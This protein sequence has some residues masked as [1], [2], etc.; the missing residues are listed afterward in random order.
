MFFYLFLLYFASFVCVCARA[1]SEVGSLKFCFGQVN[2]GLNDKLDI[3]DVGWQLN[4]ELPW[5]QR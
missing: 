5:T 3:R 4:L 1:C 2:L